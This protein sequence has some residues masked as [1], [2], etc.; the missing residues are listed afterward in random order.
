MSVSVSVSVSVSGNGKGT[1]P[2]TGRTS[3]I[4][5]PPAP[6]PTGEDGRAMDGTAMAWYITTYWSCVYVSPLLFSVAPPFSPLS[7]FTIPQHAT[8]NT[9]PRRANASTS[10]WR[11]DYTHCG[12]HTPVRT[13]VGPGGDYFDAGERRG[14][15]R[16]GVL[17]GA[18]AAVVGELVV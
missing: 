11:A 7:P 3:T 18:A 1:T 16:A 9:T 5:A 17:A 15:W 10:V 12:W 8:R 13:G 2:E 6:L 14:V 4:T